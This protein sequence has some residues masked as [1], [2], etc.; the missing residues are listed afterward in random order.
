MLTDARALDRGTEL[1]ADI[2][3][4]GAGAAGITLARELAAASRRVLL[5]ESGGFE[6]DEPTQDLYAGPTDGSSPAPEKDYLRTSRLRFLGGTTNHWEGWC[7]RFDPIDFEKRPWVPLSGWPLSRADLDPFYD[8]ALAH[9][10]VDSLEEPADSPHIDPRQFLFPPGSRLD[11]TFLRYTRPL[12]FGPFYRQELIDSAHIRLVLHANVLEIETNPE[13]TAVDRLR[14]AALGGTPFA[15]RARV[16]VLAAGAIEIP[17]LLLASNRVQKTGIGNQHDMVGRCFMEHPRIENVGAVA[18]LR[19]TASL[20]LYDVRVLAPNHQLWGALTA[21]PAMQSD[22]RLLNTCV[23]FRAGSETELWREAGRLARAVDRLQPR[24]EPADPVL[25]YATVVL[26]CEQAPNRDSRVVLDDALDPFGRPRARLQWRLA[27]SDRASAR[28]WLELLVLE[29]GRHGLG[30]AGIHLPS[31]DPWRHVI[32]SSHHIGTARMSVEPK[33]GV[34]DANLRVH[35]VANLYVA[36]AA[37]FPTSG[38][39]SPTPTIVAMTVR[40]ADHLRAVLA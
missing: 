23:A 11:T 8:R 24:S 10:Q 39:A 34:V 3:I 16:F 13:G 30:R 9:L 1:E 40:L 28:A 4:V 29:L 5:L 15:V 18:L 32:T 27:E 14:V 22:R 35:D 38:L 12:R 37:V 20:P 36:S 6:F 33:E 17:R 7:R 21:S 31:D 25:A 19:R 26:N 2:C